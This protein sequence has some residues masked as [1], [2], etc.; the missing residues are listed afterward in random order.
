MRDLSD[1]LASY[2]IAMELSGHTPTEKQIAEIEEAY[3]KEV[4]AIQEQSH[5]THLEGM[6]T[7][8]A[9]DDPR[10]YLLMHEGQ[11]DLLRPSIDRVARMY[12]RDKRL[13]LSLTIAFAATP[14]I[15]GFLCAAVL[16]VWAVL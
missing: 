14:F 13:R 10:D 8:I 12:E 2:V 7:L 11:T 6:R 16:W 15:V 9:A 4:K 3:R 5:Q 1:I